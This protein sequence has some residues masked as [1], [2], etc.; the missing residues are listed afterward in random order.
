MYQREQKENNYSEEE[1]GI[2]LERNG[3]RAIF[4][5][6]QWRLRCLSVHVNV[7]VVH[8]WEGMWGPSLLRQTQAEMSHRGSRAHPPP[9]MCV[10]VEI[11][12]LD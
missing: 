10:F 3:V 5:G 7:C 2:S 11:E 4:L 12:A 6:I 9:S 8:P 1:N